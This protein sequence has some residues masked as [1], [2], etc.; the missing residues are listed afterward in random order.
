MRNAVA[1]SETQAP[2]LLGSNGSICVYNSKPEEEGL[3][4]R[5]L[6]KEFVSFL[7]LQGEACSFLPAPEKKTQWAQWA[8]W[9]Q[10]A[11][12]DLIVSI[13]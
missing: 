10:R 8:Q 3:H 7:D 4:V 11:H 12:S 1:S 9:A 6:K 5:C 2:G 13:S